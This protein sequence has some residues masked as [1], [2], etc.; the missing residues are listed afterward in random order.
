LNLVSELADTAPFESPLTREWALRLAAKCS[1]FKS[2]L[3]APEVDALFP[4]DFDANLWSEVHKLLVSPFSGTWFREAVE[5][6]SQRWAIDGEWRS[7]RIA[8]GDLSDEHPISEKF[9]SLAL[10]LHGRPSGSCPR[11]EMELFRMLDKEH[12]HLFRFLDGA[13]TRHEAQ[14]SLWLRDLGSH[15]KNLM[16][17]SDILIRL[18]M[19][20]GRIPRIVSSPLLHPALLID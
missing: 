15:N 11:E 7:S 17:R 9:I 18:K 13:N 16:R 5:A 14:I 4:A 6:Y 8:F 12:S 1:L 2:G 19:K 20:L 10:A 3:L